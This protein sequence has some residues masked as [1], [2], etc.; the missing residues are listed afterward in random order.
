MTKEELDRL[1]RPW[2][3]V[4]V[5]AMQRMGCEIDPVWRE[6]MYG[7]YST[8]MFRWKGKDIAITIDRGLWHLSVSCNHILGYYELK[9]IRYQFLPNNM[10]VAQVFPP[11]EDFVNLH[12]FCFHLWELAPDGYAELREV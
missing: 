2:P 11:R 12:E 10:F 5:D 6:D 7:S 1:R 4:V 9:D 8:G 3:Q